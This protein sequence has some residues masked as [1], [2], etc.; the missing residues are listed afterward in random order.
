MT[1]IA[2]ARREVREHVLAR[3]GA[4]L[5]DE[6]SMYFWELDAPLGEVHLLLVGEAQLEG[7]DP[8]VRP[9]AE[10]GDVLKREAEHERDHAHRE[11]DGKVLDE[12][13]ASLRHDL[14]DELLDGGGDHLL[15]TGRASGGEEGVDELAV[16]AVLRG[17]SA[18]GLDAGVAVFFV[19]GLGLVAHEE[20]VAAGGVVGEAIGVAHD[21]GDVLEFRDEEHVAAGDRV[22]GGLVEDGVVGGVPVF[23][24][25]GGEEVDVVDAEG[26]RT[27]RATNGDFAPRQRIP[28]T[29]RAARLWPEG[30]WH[31]PASA[32]SGF[33]EDDPL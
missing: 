28:D 24:R 7:H 26:H 31:T 9:D 20:A 12:L 18:E 25:L 6:A 10:P 33:I 15:L 21:P 22:D 30:V 1:A 23:L 2:G 19:V 11:G 8:G 27:P 13:D 17:V 14:V 16:A 3:V 32:R 5:V 29:R 4:A